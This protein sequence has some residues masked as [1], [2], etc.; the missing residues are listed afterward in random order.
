MSELDGILSVAENNEDADFRLTANSQA[1][2]LF[3]L[4]YARRLEA[5]QDHPGETISDADLE[6]IT[7]LIDSAVNDVI[8]ERGSMFYA[9]MYM[10]YA[11]ELPIPDGMVDAGWLVCD[12]SLLERAIFP[13]LF[14]AI[15][16]LYTLPA[17]PGDS[18][19]VPDTDGLIR[20]GRGTVVS[21]AAVIGEYQHSLTAS[22]NGTHS[23]A[24]NDPGHTHTQTGRTLLTSAGSNT[25]PSGSFAIAQ[26]ST[27]SSVT[28][29]TVQNS[30]AGVA[31]NNI[32]PSMGTV[33]LIMSKNP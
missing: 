33:V 18:F 3:A 5:W 30:G 4:E 32:Q 12:G 7:D 29:I 8:R 26:P 14:T 15:G 1:V 25:M 9:G 27:G 31:H 19:R 6:Q 24:I 2:V 11:G 17:D 16:T 28:G 20:M 23:H 13:D 10:D 22:E 21:L